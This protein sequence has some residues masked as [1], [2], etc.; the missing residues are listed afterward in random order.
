LAVIKNVKPF[1]S[2][3]IVY[4]TELNK[5]NMDSGRTISDQLA[6]LIGSLGENMSVRR[7]VVF[8]VEPNQH[9]SWYMHGSG[10]NQSFLSQSFKVEILILKCLLAAK[11]VN[12]CHFGNYGALV[13]MTFKETN[14]NYNV[15]LYDRKQN[16]FQ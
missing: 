8:N 15:I 3:E 9:L 10:N 4:K 7:A 16:E 12:Q 2:K 14:L 5:I 13:N 6:L 1:G 11:P